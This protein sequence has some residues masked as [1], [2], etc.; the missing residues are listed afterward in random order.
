VSS[1]AHQE[2]QGPQCRQRPYRPKRFKNSLL[3]SLS[4]G[5]VTT[6]VKITPPNYFEYEETI[7]PPNYELSTVHSI[8]L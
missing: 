6:K 2:D 1:L 4:I 3:V 5:G 7:T 8:E